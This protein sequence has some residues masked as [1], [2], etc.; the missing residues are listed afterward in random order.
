VLPLT[1]IRPGTTVGTMCR[2][3]GEISNAILFGYTNK[4]HDGYLG[5]SYIGKWVN[6]GAGTTTSNLK[7]TYGEISVMTPKGPQRT[8]RTH[9]GSLL[10]DH[11]KTAIGTRLMAGTYV[12]FASMLAGSGIAEKFVPSLTFWTDKGYEPY[13]LEKAIEVMKTVFGRRDRTWD[14]VDETVVR[15]AA[16]IAPEIEA[17]R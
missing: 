12:G 8:G 9:I 13:R 11:V 17:K 1:L 3:G 5:D 4:A 6:L 7:N 2:V 15:Y 16:G 10:G 14:T